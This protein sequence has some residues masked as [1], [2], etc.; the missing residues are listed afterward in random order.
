MSTAPPRD[1]NGTRPLV[2]WPL[3]WQVMAAKRTETRPS[4]WAVMAAR[5]REW[6]K[7]N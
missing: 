3:F 4:W 6:L 1:Y 5:L 7:A 2:C